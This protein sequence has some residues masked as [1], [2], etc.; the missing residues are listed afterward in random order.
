MAKLSVNDGLLHVELS[1]MERFRSGHD[2]FSVELWRVRF[3]VTDDGSRRDKLGNQT[4]GR[5]RHC[6]SFAKRGETAF[7][8]WPKAGEAVIVQ[9]TDPAWGEI[10]IGDKNAKEVA[11]ALRLEVVRGKQAAGL[12]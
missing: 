2:S 12:Q 1:A 7:V 6:G 3:I 10:I 11:S 4:A 9:L 8:H 5:N